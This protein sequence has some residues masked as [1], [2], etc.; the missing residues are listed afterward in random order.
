MDLSFLLDEFS[1]L[2]SLEE[3]LRIALRL[4]AALV[5]GGAVGW[6]RERAGKAAGLRTH[7]LVALGA[8]LVLVTADRM[9]MPRADQSR[10]I[11]GIVAGVGF[12]GGGAILKIADEKKI[13][14]LTTAAGIWMTASIG[15]AAGAG[16]L[17]T[18][19]LAAVLAFI[20]LRALHDFEERL[21][22]PSGSETA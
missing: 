21:G 3:F 16:K 5:L 7:M 8:A 1:D 6:E 11:Q 20:V 17:A 22:P 2:P 13:K 15:I 12:L 4:A 9:G 18:A 19:T 10:V 14:G